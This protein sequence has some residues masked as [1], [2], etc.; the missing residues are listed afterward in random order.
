MKKIFV[1]V[2][3]LRVS[4][5][6]FARGSGG[7]LQHKIDRAYKGGTSVFVNNQF[8]T[9]V[10]VTKLEKMHGSNPRK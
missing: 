8:A 10:T 6:A 7:E 1:V 5:F 9:P 2:L 3:F 4:G